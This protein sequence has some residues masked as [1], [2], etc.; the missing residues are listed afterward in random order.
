MGRERVITV[1]I[2]RRPKNEWKINV[3]IFKIARLIFY[4]TKKKKKS[5]VDFYECTEI[6]HSKRS[7]GVFSLFKISPGEI[8]PVDGVGRFI[9][10]QGH[11]VAADVV[12]Q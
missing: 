1:D 2:P 11:K 3:V 7:H 8:A 10:G 9:I 6:Q 5:H 12:I 4:L